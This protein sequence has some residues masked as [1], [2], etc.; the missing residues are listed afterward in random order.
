[1][2]GYYLRLL[3]SNGKVRVVEI[4]RLTDQELANWVLSMD[5]QHAKR[6]VLSLV[7]WIRQNVREEP[8]N[9]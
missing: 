7:R 8:A 1:M 2:T 6:W 4:E 5:G 3:A 9:N